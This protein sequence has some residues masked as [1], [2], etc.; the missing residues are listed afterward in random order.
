MEEFIRN[1]FKKYEISLS[2]EQ[3][4]MFITYLK[5][6]KEANEKFNITAITEDNE[7]IIK[8]FLDSV[9]LSKYIDFNEIESMIDIGTGGGFPGLPLKILYPHLKVTLLDSLNKRIN[10]LNDL[11]LKLGLKD[12][13]AVHG[14]SE[15]MGNKEEYREKYDLAVSRAVA[16]LNII[17]EYSIPFV[18]KGG[19]FI[20]LKKNE[21]DE[22][23]E[24]STKAVE[25]LGGKIEKV[26]KY[27]LDEIDMYHSLVFIKKVENTNKKYPRTSK[28]I[29]EKSL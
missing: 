23:L 10:F 5:E 20:P 22:E 26:E 12:I 17:G 13:E 3:I 8:H 6:L 7:I 27:K 14:R 18:K 15:E 9:I 4:S 29:K 2:D 24:K 25:I 16:Y 28:Q 1:L 21:L 11:I 19:Y